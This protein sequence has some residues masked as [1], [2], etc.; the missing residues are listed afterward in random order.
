[1]TRDH[2]ES[3]DEVLGALLAG[4]ARLESRIAAMEAADRE[5]PRRTLSAI[6]AAALALCVPVAGLVW[7]QGSTTGVVL[8]RLDRVAVDVSDVRREVQGHTASIG[9]LR[10][11]SNVNTSR[12]DD[13]RD[14]LKAM[15]H[16]EGDHP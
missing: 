10:T 16:T 6:A 11:N 8:E 4:V 1:M 13:L 3:S 7:Y 2:A 12:I 14:A 9:D 15:R 5:R